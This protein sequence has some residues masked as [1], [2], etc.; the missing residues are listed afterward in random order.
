MTH[1]VEVFTGATQAHLLRL[2]R[3]APHT[4]PELAAALDVTDNAVRLHI[5]ALR[6]DGLVDE[7][8]VERAT[9]GKPA[10]RYGLT[11]LG[12]ELFPKAYAQVLQG[13]IDESMRRDGRTRTVALLRA[14][15]ARLG[16]TP[17]IPPHTLKQR[18]D[19]AAAALRGLGADI[20][21]HRTTE[22]WRL[23]GRGCP[24]AAV[25]RERPEVCEL[26]RA[27][28]KE[29]TGLAVDECCERGEHPHCAFAISA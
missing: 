20:E 4:I 21:V 28:V 11:R 6:R 2:L 8:G 10:R 25:A 15:G 13:L 5:A 26:G 1:R 19:A 9:G 16:A 7:A 27:L 29:I 3:R 14:L 17:D 12:E 24:L 18:V 23:Q 22:G